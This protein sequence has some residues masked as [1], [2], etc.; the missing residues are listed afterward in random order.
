MVR[1]PAALLGLAG[2]AAAVAYFLVAPSLPGGAPAELAAAVG[3]LAVA[4]CAF[5]P[6]IGRDDPAALLVFGGGA[7]LLAVALNASDVGAAATPVEAV[8][9]AAAGMLFAI[10]FPVPTAVVAVPLVVGGIDLAT[11][12][13]A[14]AEP[15]VQ[16]GDA[17]SV[18]TLALPAWGGG[19]DAARLA[20][21]DAV[22]LG[23]YAAWALRYDLAPRRTLPALAAA[24]ALAAVLMV[25]LDRPF[26]A[27][28]LLALALLLPAAPKIPHLLRGEG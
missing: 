18:L 7:A 28:P 6:L 5:A 1:G 11:A 3:A 22:F 27:L 10:A 19:L 14:G 25:A 20:L 21:L 17:P 12:L 8:L 24:T 13:G 23:L 26:P 16:P 4:A 2:L 15:V 9:G